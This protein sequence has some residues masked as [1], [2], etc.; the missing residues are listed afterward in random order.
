[1]LARSSCFNFFSYNRRE[2]PREDPKVLQPTHNVLFQFLF[3]PPRVARIGVDRHLADDRN[4]FIERRG[5]PR[6]QKGTHTCCLTL[7]LLSNS[8]SSSG[9]KLT[10]SAF[11]SG[12]TSVGAPAEVPPVGPLTLLRFRFLCEAP[13][14][15]D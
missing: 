10:I 12:M 9:F 5:H 11:G 15:A 7:S 6:T 13:P 14:A 2:E 3:L 1:M 4:D 8:F